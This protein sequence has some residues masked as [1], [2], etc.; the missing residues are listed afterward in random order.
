MAME[1]LSAMRAVSQ[2]FDHLPFLSPPAR[3]FCSGSTRVF[4]SLCR[5]AVSKACTLRG[6]AGAAGSKHTVWHL[7]YDFIVM[8]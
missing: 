1:K 8:I 7:N 4:V 3:C 6:A 2:R 5:Y